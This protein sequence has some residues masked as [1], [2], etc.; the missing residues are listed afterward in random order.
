MQLEG[1]LPGAGDPPVGRP[2]R[3]AAHGPQRGN[4]RGRGG[5][6]G[7]GDGGAGP[8]PWPRGRPR[9]AAARTSTPRR[10][11]YGRSPLRSTPP[12]TAAVVV[13]SR[14]ISCGV[15]GGSRE[16]RPPP[17]GSATASAGRDRI[18][19]RLRIPGLRTARAVGLVE[20]RSSSVQDRFLRNRHVDL[21]AMPRLVALVSPHGFGHA[22]RT[23]AVLAALAEL[24][25]ET[26]LEIWSTVPEWFFRDSLG[27]IRFD[28]RKSLHDVGLVQRTALA[29]DLPA[30]VAALGALWRGDAVE[31]LARELE[32]AHADAVLCDISPLGL[33]AA[34][35][36]GLRSILL[37]NFTWDW[38][39]E[40]YLDAEPRLRP[41]V[42]T[43]RRDL[44]RRR[45]PPARGAG[46]SRFFC[47]KSERLPW[48]GGRGGRRGLRGGWWS[49]RAGGFGR[50]DRAADSLRR[51]GGAGAARDLPWSADGAGV[52][53]RHRDRVRESRPLAHPRR[54][55]FRGAGR[56]GPR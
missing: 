14:T 15:G 52:A 37:E 22:A 34:R 32:R 40:G 49:F 18:R 35:R 53:R 43:L 30:T 25:P 44:F 19:S 11:A 6:G 29:E 55:R 50:A 46:L 38:I 10:R 9:S 24:A 23:A 12:P 45:S 54:R 13:R 2:G 33:A 26:T 3:V 5:R 56:C 16:G 7:R 8:E 42:R 48:K 31:E 20:R 47:F 1:R 28:Y 36:A 21:R 17:S 39:Y 27:S 41:W 4:R 51:G